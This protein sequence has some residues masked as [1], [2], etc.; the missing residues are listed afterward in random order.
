MSKMKFN[1]LKRILSDIVK[2]KAEIDLFDSSKP[3]YRK[4]PEKIM[5]FGPKMGRIAKNGQFKIFSPYFNLRVQ[6]KTP[7]E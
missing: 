4:K 1:L 7:K 2:L 6:S 3:S 5:I